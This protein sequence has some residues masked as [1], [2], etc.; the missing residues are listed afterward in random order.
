MQDVKKKVGGQIRRYRQADKMTI[1]EL[2]KKIH[3]GK[4]T[5]SKYENGEIA[6]DIETLAEIAAAL[7]ITLNELVQEEEAPIERMEQGA[8]S[9]REYMYFY[10]GRAKRVSKSVLE[11]YRT[12]REDR[13]KVVLFY[14]VPALSETG[15]C[16]AL[17]RGYMTKYAFI[18]N[19]TFENQ[20]NSTEQAFLYS[21]D[22]LEFSLNKTGVLSGLSSRT[23]LPVSLK[24]VLAAEPQKE[25]EE[26]VQSLMLSKEDLR[27]TKKY[28][29]LTLEKI[30]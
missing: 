30:L 8:F 19:Y 5:V 26:F 13:M 14:D 9:H 7:R 3:K 24:V 4:S 21:F 12:S 22:S 2:A 17:Y 25:D 20:K 18:S 16:R 28:N 29:M 23:M 6:V 27:L 10:D 1:E 15:K 11:H